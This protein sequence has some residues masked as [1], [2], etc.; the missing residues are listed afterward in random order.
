M[1]DKED[2]IPRSSN[3]AR[4]DQDREKKDKGSVRLA[5]FPKS[6]KYT[7]VLEIS[8]LSSTIY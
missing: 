2:G 5:D 6:Q 8:Q 1:E 3:K 7:E 4:R